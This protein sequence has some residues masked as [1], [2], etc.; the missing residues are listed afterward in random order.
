[1]K[2]YETKGCSQYG[3]QMGRRSRGVFFPDEKIHLY[4]VPLDSGGYDKGG[5]YWGCGVRLYCAEA[6]DAIY[7]FRASNRAC[8]KAYVKKE[9]GEDLKFYR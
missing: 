7:Y 1:M 3:A 6:E 8:A 5:A 2:D 9:F 4:N